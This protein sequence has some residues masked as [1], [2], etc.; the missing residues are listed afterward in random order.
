MSGWIN[1]SGIIAGSSSTE[2]GYSA[3][4]WDV[5]GKATDVGVEVGNLSEV[6]AINE[7]GIMAGQVSEAGKYRVVRWDEQGQA[8]RLPTLGGAASRFRALNGE[9]MV[10]GEADSADRLSVPVYWD[11]DGQVFAL[12]PVA[13]DEPYAVSDINDHGVIVGSAIVPDQ[14]FRAVVWRTR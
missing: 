10:V 11:R 7:R 5:A 3:V 2:G 9:G 6:L 12:P 8:T 1:G 4:R 13:A 14:Y